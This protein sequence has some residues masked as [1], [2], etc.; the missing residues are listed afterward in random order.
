MLHSASPLLLPCSPL[1]L[2]PLSPSPPGPSPAARAMASRPGQRHGL[3][4]SPFRS[5]P[6][7]CARQRRWVDTD[8]GD[9]ATSLKGRRARWISAAPRVD[10]DGRPR[11]AARRRGK[12][13][14]RAHTD[15]GRGNMAAI[16]LAV[17]PASERNGDPKLNCSRSRRG[18]C[19]GQFSFKNRGRQRRSTSP[20]GRQ[21]RRILAALRVDG[22]NRPQIL[23]KRR[24]SERGRRQACVRGAGEP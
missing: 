17:E 20:K 10:G 2:L 3:P 6:P 8:S 13:V 1:A 18:R 11:V 14:K 24:G 5:P 7:Q 19:D 4:L 23:A 22:H 9:R 16:E 15:F 12:R 21:A